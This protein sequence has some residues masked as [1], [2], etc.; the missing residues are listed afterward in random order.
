MSCKRPKNGRSAFLLYFSRDPHVLSVSLCVDATTRSTARS[1]CTRTT[2]TIATWSAARFLCAAPPSPPRPA[3]A[4]VRRDQQ[5]S[6][7]LLTACLPRTWHRQRVDLCHRAARA[8]G[9]HLRRLQQGRGQCCCLWVSLSTNSVLVAA[10]RALWVDALV[11]QIKAL[12]AADVKMQR[13]KVRFTL[14]CP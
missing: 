9:A 3:P 8:A 7:C 4:K 5:A 13:H 10:Q 11:S 6:V 14:T 12:P 1:C 2:S